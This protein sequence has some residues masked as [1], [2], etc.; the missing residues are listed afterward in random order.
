MKLAFTYSVF[1]ICQITRATEFL[2]L[3][4]HTHTNKTRNIFKLTSFG[5]RSP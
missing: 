4:T 5:L 1:T 2:E 3:G